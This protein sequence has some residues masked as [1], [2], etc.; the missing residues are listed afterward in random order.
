MNSTTPGHRGRRTQAER[1]ATT[2]SALLAAAADVI[3]EFG[4]DALTLARVGD[5]AGYSRGI[6]THH[7]GSKQALLDA[8][9]RNAQSGLAAVV[10]N[11]DPGIDRLLLFIEEYL[12]SIGDSD[13]PWSAFLLLWV[14]A[15][16]SAELAQI[17]RDRDDYVREHLCKDIAA[18]RDQGQIS[19]D[20]DPAAV[21]VALIGQLRG[22]GLQLLLDPAA[23][24][25]QRLRRSV[26]TL[27]RRALVSDGGDHA[28][29]G[30]SSDLDASP[31][32]A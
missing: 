27:W 21:A 12:D 4:V 19:A 9:A 3:V 7:F 29:A 15:A 16:T 6:V 31:T 26:P 8:V 17:M 11:E 18:G 25:L 28:A 32:W 14:Q 22:I 13:R 5:R 1:R 20:V 30:G 23:V 2:K 10:E 24:D